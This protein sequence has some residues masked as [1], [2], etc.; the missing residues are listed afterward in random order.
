VWISLILTGDD[1]R[2]STY[3]EIVKLIR[4]IGTTDAIV[5]YPKI[6]TYRI[7]T[8]YTTP[9]IAAILRGSPY[10]VEFLLSHG[11]GIN[12]TRD[13]IIGSPLDYALYTLNSPLVDF[14]IDQG[15][16]AIRPVT[17]SPDEL[18]FR[19]LYLDYPPNSPEYYRALSAY[20]GVGP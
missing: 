5:L 14:L 17:T 16:Q 13:Q 2:E 10:L 18:L 19:Q 12:F 3:R 11:A 9:L 6:F 1:R 7:P 15:A 4:S 8:P 20:Q